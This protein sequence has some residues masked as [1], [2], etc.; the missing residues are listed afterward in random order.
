MIE[1]KNVVRF[2][3]QPE[4]RR[5]RRYAIE[6]E[7][8]YRVSYRDQISQAGVG[9]LINISLSGILFKSERPIFPGAPLTVVMNCAGLLDQT[10]PTELMIQGRVVR[11]N[12]KGTASTIE[13]YEFR[14]DSS[15]AKSCRLSTIL[16][17]STAPRFLGA[18][19]PASKTASATLIT[20]PAVRQA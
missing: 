2:D 11:S 8:R 3:G 4:R 7:V 13:R 12:E 18:T 1:K 14:S 16:V 10:S 19:A 9:R 15:A 17:L 6:Q 20:P 5:T